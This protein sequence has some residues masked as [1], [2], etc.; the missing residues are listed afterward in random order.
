MY[1]SDIHIYYLWWISR[2][3]SVYLPG[4]Y[5]LGGSIGMSMVGYV[6]FI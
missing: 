2:I 1:Y 5:L 4:A 3:V 6:P